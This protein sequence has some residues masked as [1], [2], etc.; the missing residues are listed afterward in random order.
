MQLV[1]IVADRFA[2]ARMT[3]FQREFVPPVLYRVTLDLLLVDGVWFDDPNDTPN[4]FSATVA[5]TKLVR[6][7]HVDFAGTAAA[8]PRILC[9]LATG[10]GGTNWAAPEIEWR[11]P[12]LFPNSSFEDGVDFPTGWT[13]SANPSLVASHFGRTGSRCL[14]PYESGG[15]LYDVAIELEVDASTEYTISAHVGTK[16]LASSGTFRIMVTEKNAA[17]ATIGV[18]SADTATISSPNWTRETYVKTSNVAAASWIVAFQSITAGITLNVDDV[19]LEKGAA[20]TEF[21][22]TSDPQWEPA[23]FT[24]ADGLDTT[25]AAAGNPDKMVVDCAVGRTRVTNGGIWV[26]ANDAVNGGYF[27]VHPGMNHLYVSAPASGSVAVEVVV[28]EVYF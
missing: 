6:Y 26:E 19:Q 24:H 20:A 27:D 21:V 8:W 16:L 1:E 13:D 23:S 10:G 22:D 28:P 4:S 3:A 9:T 25:D 15:S 14:Q 18:P 7:V 5:S 17:G 12:N 2:V 11:G